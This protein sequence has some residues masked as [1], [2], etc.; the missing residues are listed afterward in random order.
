MGREMSLLFLWVSLCVCVS[1]LLVDRQPH[2]LVALILVI[3]LALPSTAGRL[4][5][6]AWEGAVAIHPSSILTLVVLAFVLYSHFYAAISVFLRHRWCSYG[7]VSVVVLAA[8]ETALG[9]HLEVLLRFL[10]VVVVP[11]SLSFIIL[12]TLRTWFQVRTVAM[13]IVVI[14]VVEALLGIAQS[15]LHSS[16][17]F[18][19]YNRAQYWWPADNRIDRALGTVDSPLD[20]AFL[21]SVS[22]PLCMVFKG[23]L[24]RSLVS[25]TL[26]LGVL[27]SQS[28]LGLICS[29]FG[30]SFVALYSILCDANVRRSASSV[31]TAIVVPVSVVAVSLVTLGAG[32][33]QRISGDD[34]NSSVRRAEAL[35]YFW[36]RLS[37]RIF[38]GDGFGSSFELFG[39]TLR[40]SFESGYA[41]F[42]YDLG[43]IVV[44]VLV[45]TQM[46]A[47][48]Y[49]L[50]ARALF[51]SF[52]LVLAI[53]IS[54]GYSSFATQGPAGMLAWALVGMCVAARDSSYAVN[55]PCSGLSFE[56]LRSTPFSSPQ[57]ASGV[58]RL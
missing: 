28:R 38:A 45:A 49:G 37:S 33:L 56:T 58:W 24:S 13:V 19:T 26:L 14:A 41:I 52:S 34:G 11:I 7:L 36:S 32:V 8:V 23:I 39:S 35:D 22:I 57:A 31:V 48:W 40:T 21:C 15:V 25:G 47:V 43:L 2:V 5:T 17:L 4:I 16:L 44:V 42:V 27:A 29:L 46:C 53:V 6:G 3:R 50:R 18:E 20:L 12:A 51:L 9:Q 30:I 10:N 1:A 54:A 55:D